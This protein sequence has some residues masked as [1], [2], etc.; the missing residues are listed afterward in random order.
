MK[1]EEILKQSIKKAIKGGWDKKIGRFWLKQVKYGDSHGKLF[2][3][4]HDFAKA[5]FGTELIPVCQNCRK[6]RKDRFDS[7][8]CNGMIVAYEMLRLWQ[9]HGQKLFLAKNRLKYLQQFLECQE[10]V[11]E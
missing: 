2:I 6:I 5:F 9:H 8:C 3:F 10:E 4:N 7:S 11:K 1:N